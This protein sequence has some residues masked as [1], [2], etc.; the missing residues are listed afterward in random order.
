MPSRATMYMKMENFFGLL[1]LEKFCARHTLYVCVYLGLRFGVVCVATLHRTDYDTNFCRQDTV[2][3]C[4]T[5]AAVVALP[6]TRLS[7]STTDATAQPPSIIVYHENKR[8]VAYLV[9]ESDMKYYN[10]RTSYTHNANASCTKRSRSNQTHTT[11]LFCSRC[12]RCDGG[13]GAGA[14]AGGCWQ[15]SFGASTQFDS[16]I[17]LYNCLSGRNFVDTHPR[18]LCL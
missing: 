9:A 1:P 10:S 8:L 7:S 3:R 11:Y 18:S 16:I 15:N 6:P 2:L 12:A 4:T 14:G 13:G 17:L 5:A